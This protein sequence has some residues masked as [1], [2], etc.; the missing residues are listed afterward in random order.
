MLTNAYSKGYCCA[1]GVVFALVYWFMLANSTSKTASTGWP[2][3]HLKKN[4]S[5]NTQ[6]Y[7]HISHIVS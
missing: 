2:T 1:A 7:T 3:T 4:N 5:Q 6:T